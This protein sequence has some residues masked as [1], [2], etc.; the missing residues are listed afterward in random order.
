[1]RLEPDENGIGKVNGGRNGRTP[2][3]PGRGSSRTSVR[4]NQMSGQVQHGLLV[5]LL[6]YN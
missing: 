5:V 4:N 1:M 3:K 6:L 2:L